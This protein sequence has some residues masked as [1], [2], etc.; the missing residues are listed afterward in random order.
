MYAWYN[1]IDRFFNMYRFSIVVKTL[2]YLNLVI[3]Y[4]HVIYFLFF[5]IR[6]LNKNHWCKDWFIGQVPWPPYRCQMSNPWWCHVPRTRSPQQMFLFILKIPTQLPLMYILKGK[7]D[8]VLIWQMSNQPRI[9]SLTNCP[10]FSIL[11]S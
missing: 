5:I 7:K 11:N 1:M 6:I 4:F 9:C 8:G 2:P 10:L 3:Y